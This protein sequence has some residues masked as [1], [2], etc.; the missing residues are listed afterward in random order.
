MAEAVEIPAKDTPNHI[1][2]TLKEREER[3]IRAGHR[4]FDEDRLVKACGDIVLNGFDV[5]AF[6]FRK[7]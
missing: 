1:F 5:W 2:G 3:A 7:K 6:H 4:T